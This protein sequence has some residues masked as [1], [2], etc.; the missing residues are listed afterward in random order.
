MKNNVGRKTS[1]WTGYATRSVTTTRPSSSSGVVPTIE[2]RRSPWR[3]LLRD[4]LDRVRTEDPASPAGSW[5]PNGRHP[6]HPA[7]ATHVDVPSS[8]SSVAMARR[9][10]MRLCRI[11]IGWGKAPADQ[12]G[13]ALCRRRLWE[14]MAPRRSREF[15][16]EAAKALTAPSQHPDARQ[17]PA[18]LWDVP[19]MA[20]I[21]KQIRDSKRSTAGPRV[22][23]GVF[24]MEIYIVRVNS[25]SFTCVLSL[26]LSMPIFTC[27]ILF[28]TTT[29]NYIND[30]PFYQIPPMI[31]SMSDRKSVV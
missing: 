11:Q 28:M 18:Q 17:S 8:M 14:G 7:S 12:Q 6:E 13:A 19:P 15:G 1:W 22:G 31:C 20:F 29:V 10:R 26:P 4:H 21:N 27:P 2:E 3:H 25:S 16:R 9:C 24:S 23:L 30:N 5:R